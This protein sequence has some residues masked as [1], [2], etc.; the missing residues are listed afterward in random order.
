MSSKA[1]GIIGGMGPEAT[2]DLMVKVIRTTPAKIDQDHI[3]MFVDNNPKVPCR[4]KAI[5]GD[6]ANPGPVMAQM[7]EGLEKVGADFLV[8]PCNTAHYYID[9]VKDAVQVDVL[10]MVE[11]TVKVLK[12]DEMKKVALLATSALI[13]TNLYIKELTIA[14]I[15][16]VL[17]QKDYQQMVMEVTFAVKSG[18]F[19]KAESYVEKIISHVVDMGSESMVLGC[20][21]LPL[22]ISREK[23]PFKFYDPTN[24]LAKAIRDRGTVLLSRLPFAVDID[25]FEM[26]LF[27]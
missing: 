14:E 11:E 24:I 6:G 2:I 8:I 22:V 7:A 3:R 4:I 27:I 15:E 18:D 26:V 20:T 23:Y 1:V 25:S 10:N 16:V 17:P 19:S 13:N 21:E 5:L 12:K 9:Y